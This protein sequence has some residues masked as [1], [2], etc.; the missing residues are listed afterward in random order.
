MPGLAAT[1]LDD[2]NGSESATVGRLPVSAGTRQRLAVASPARQLFELDTV[3]SRWQSALDST[4]RALT[5]AGGHFGLPASEL[6]E[7]RRELVRERQEIAHLL[8]ALAK[9]T[10]VPAPWLSAVPITPRALGLDADA[11]ACLFDLDFVLTDSAA[12]HA[13]AWAEVFDA[14]LLRLAEEMRSHFPPF[15]PV[16][17]YDAYLDGRPRLEGV[18]AFL[19]SRGVRLPEGRLDDSSATATAY[20]LARR[21]GDVLAR[22]LRQHGITARPAARRY[23]EAC[24]HA[25]LDRA[26]LSASTSTDSMLEVAHLSALIEARI[27]AGVMRA[28]HL[29]SRPAPDA[30]LAACRRLAVRPAETVSFTHSAAGVVAARAAGVAVIGVAT[31]RAAERLRAYGA[32]RVV[33]SLETLLEH[34]VLPRDIAAT[35]FGRSR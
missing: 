17:D 27:D 15:D 18:H 6:D 9:D 31:G 12:L 13:S 25:G 10:G 21:K 1:T 26:V 7:Q 3:A 29:R 23:L 5:A 8:V 24:G 28:D 11:R 2:A 32:E 16:R 34:G 19:D 33:A 4:Q 22:I 14:F 35:R 30:V 20:G